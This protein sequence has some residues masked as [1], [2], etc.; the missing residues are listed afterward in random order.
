MQANQG[1][2]VTLGASRPIGWYDR[3]AQRLARPARRLG[4]WLIFWCGSTVR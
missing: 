4:P 2:S 3:S 1:D